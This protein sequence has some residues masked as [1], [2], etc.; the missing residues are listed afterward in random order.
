MSSAILCTAMAHI[1]GSSAS[2]IIRQTL[3]QVFSRDFGFVSAELGVVACF[4]AI[5]MEQLYQVA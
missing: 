4:L 1:L 3:V 2:R 5:F